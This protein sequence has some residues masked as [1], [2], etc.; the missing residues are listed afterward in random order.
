M[1][2]SVKQTLSVIGLGR[3]GS[4]WAKEL[5][6]FFDVFVFDS[7]EK[8]LAPAEEFATAIS[9]EKALQSDYIYLTIPIRAIEDFLIKN[10]SLIGEN[11]VLIDAAS[12]KTPV[13]GWFEKHLRGKREF[14]FTH[15]LFGPDSGANGL[16][17]L[18]IAV[19]PGEIAYSKYKRIIDAFEAAKLNVL[20][21]TADEHDY[22]MAYNLNLI[23]LLG[24]ALA[25][26][27]IAK[28]PLKMNALTYLNGMSRYVVNDSRILF[29]DFF[30]FNP[31]A[32]KIKTDLIKNLNE[33]LK[34]LP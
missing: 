23:H 7:D 9:L 19:F 34:T 1:G 14:M 5:S 18:S 26:M 33:I 30:R 29:E 12:I 25:G 3:F 22:L 20:A 11:S 4:F 16:N 10:A 31:Y 15:P 27:G 32:E 2:K 21:L 13:V 24:R 8:K 28:I 6:R 17:G